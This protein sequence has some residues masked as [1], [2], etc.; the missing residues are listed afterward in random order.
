MYKKIMS[1][2]LN[3]PPGVSP[4]AE[5]LLR[6]LLDRDANTRL[7]AQGAQQI[8]DHPFFTDV[9]WRRLLAKKYTPPFRPNVVSKTLH[10]VGNS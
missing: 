4:V 7:G 6:K 5:D 8:K 2:P 9:D 1:E 3:F 10:L